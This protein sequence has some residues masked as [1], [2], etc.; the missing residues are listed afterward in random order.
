MDIEGLNKVVVHKMFDVYPLSTDICCWW[1]C[2]KFKST[3]VPYPKYYDE[4]KNTYKCTG[5]FCSFSCAKAYILHDNY[6]KK[7]Q[8]CQ[9]LKVIAKVMGIPS[10][11]PII[12]APPRAT[13]KIFGGDL[14]IDEFRSKSINGVSITNALPLVCLPSVYQVKEIVPNLNMNT[15]NVKSYKQNDSYKMMNLK[16]SKPLPNHKGTLEHTMGLTIKK[17]DT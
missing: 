9:H 6:I 17:A 3:P 4:L 16:R 14:T 11:T 2:H 7:F 8:S 5:I 15:P 10:R 1:C 12:T 13:L